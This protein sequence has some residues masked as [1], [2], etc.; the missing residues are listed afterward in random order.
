MA[1]LRKIRSGHQARQWGQYFENIV[2]SHAA[3]QNTT[4]IRIP[5]GCRVIRNGTFTK[6][7]RVTTPFDFVLMSKN[8]VVVFDAKTVDASSFPHSAITPHQLNSLIKCTRDAL[9]GYL[10]W[11]RE[12][13]LVSFITAKRLAESRPR[14]SMIPDDGLVLGNCRTMDLTKLF[15]NV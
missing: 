2:Q 10:V 13:D 1:T 12:P 11:F 14:T 3:R 4:L 7:M 8:N 5:D 15:K 6:L 9:A